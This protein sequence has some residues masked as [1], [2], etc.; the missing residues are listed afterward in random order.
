MNEEKYDLCIVFCFRT[1]DTILRKENMWDEML[2]TNR[3][4]HIIS[5]SCS[6]IVVWVILV[7]KL[8]V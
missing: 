5:S 6:T 8:Q 3:S 2:I 4:R 7:D 1:F